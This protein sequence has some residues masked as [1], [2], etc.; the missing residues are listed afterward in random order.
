MNRRA[1]DAARPAQERRE[2]GSSPPPRPTLQ[3]H[4]PPQAVGS[5]H[6]LPTPTGRR[7][8]AVSPQRGAGDDGALSHRR[9]PLLPACA[10]TQAPD[11]ASRAPAHRVARFPV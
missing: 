2:S 4:L 3:P 10:V 11:T 1:G 9:P 7:A 6:L 8:T 5:V